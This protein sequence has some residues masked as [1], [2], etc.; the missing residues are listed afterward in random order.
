MSGLGA[1][2]RMRETASSAR[3]RCRAHRARVPRSPPPSASLSSRT[4]AGPWFRPVSRSRR[5]RAFMRLGHL[6]RR[7][8]QSETRNARAKALRP[9]PRQ[10]GVASSQRPNQE[11]VRKRPTIAR[12]SQIRGQA[13]SHQRDQRARPTRRANRL[14][15]GLCV[16]NGFGPSLMPKSPAKR[17]LSASPSGK[18]ARLPPMTSGQMGTDRILP[19]INARRCDHFRV[20]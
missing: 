18:L 15:R 14:S 13:R 2:T 9:A 7:S 12:G 20:M 17:S 19:G 1:A 16:G 10:T 3:F 4:R 6:R 8:G 5:S 11:R